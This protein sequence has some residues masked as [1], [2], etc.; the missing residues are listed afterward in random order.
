MLC[1]YWKI[2][3][4]LNSYVTIQF[5]S[6]NIQLFEIFKYLS[7]LHNAVFGNYNGD[8]GRQERNKLLR[9]LVPIDA[10]FSSYSCQNG[11]YSQSPF[12]VTRVTEIIAILDD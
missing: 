6:K 10:V 11:D 12:W 2:F 1:E 9:S 8:Y 4:N 3:E 7:L 5:S